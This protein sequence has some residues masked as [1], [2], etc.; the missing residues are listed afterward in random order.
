[1]M[2]GS[3]TT[4]PVR[5][6]Y[7]EPLGPTPSG[8]AS[9]APAWTRLAVVAAILASSG[10][11]RLWQ[12]RRVEQVLEAGRVSPFPLASLPMSI[13][14]WEGKEASLDPQVVRITGSTDLIA[15]R[16]VDRRTGVGVDVIVLYGPT[17]DMMFHVPEVCYP[18]AGYEAM[19]GVFERSVALDE[20]SKT[21]PFRSLAYTKGEGGL[22][23]AQDVYYSFRYGGRWTTQPASHKAARRMPGM[24]KV[25]AS[26]R[27]SGRERRDV[28]N[29]AEPLL[30]ALVGEIEARLAKSEPDAA[31]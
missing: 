20:G 21:V 13:G 16:Y 28:D 23:D 8:R 26:R 4:S 18:S 25:Q 17:S 11:A 7:A 9:V 30:A 19:P 2:S 29:P 22:A 6:R 15:R 10:A 31:E 1:M 12:E 5:S 24:F 14:S 3:P 27:I